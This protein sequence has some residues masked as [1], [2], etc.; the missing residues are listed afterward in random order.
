MSKEIRVIQNIQLTEMHN[1]AIL[2]S[3]DSGVYY[4]LDEIGL[5]IW[6]LICMSEDSVNIEKIKTYLLGIYHISES[7]E[8]N[9]ETD[10]NDFVYSLAS[11]GLV[12]II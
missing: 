10:I 12:E 1:E 8:E 3:I 7:D 4:S 11:K 6:Q 5:D 9:L 2:L